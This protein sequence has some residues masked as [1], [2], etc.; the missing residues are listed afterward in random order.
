MAVHKLF[1]GRFFGQK[2]VYVG[3]FTHFGVNF[4]WHF[5]ILHRNFRYAIILPVL[6]GRP[7]G[8]VPRQKKRSAHN[9]AWQRTMEYRMEV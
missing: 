1:T 7:G 5:Y 3:Y 6:R 8:E 2:F 9:D 4:V